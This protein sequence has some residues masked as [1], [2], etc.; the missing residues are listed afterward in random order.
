MIAPRRRRAQSAARDEIRRAR[1][2]SCSLP[3]PPR[4]CPPSAPQHRSAFTS[5]IV[6][7]CVPICVADAGF[8]IVCI[9][10]SRS[11]T[12]LAFALELVLPY[13]LVCIVTRDCRVW[14]RTALSCTGHI[15]MTLS[16]VLVAA[17]C[18]LG[19]R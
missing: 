18:V 14:F 5:N 11:W 6:R 1:G 12:V 9:V 16:V 15:V 19:L 2:Y 10:D 4:E 8:G 7:A 13:A 3:Q 17:A